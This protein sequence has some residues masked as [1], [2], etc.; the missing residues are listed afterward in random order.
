[1]RRVLTS[2]VLAAILLLSIIVVSAPLLTAHDPLEIRMDQVLQPPSGD[3]PIGT[4]E[5][6]RDV[7]ARLLYGGRIS[8]AV[9]FLSM[10]L[11]VF[12]GVLL[13]TISGLAGGITDRVIMRLADLLL[14]IPSLLLM[15]GFLAIMPQSL[16]S[17]ILVISVTGWMMVARIVRTDIMATKQ[18]TYVLAAMKLGAGPARSFMHHLLPQCI[19]SII[20]LAVSSASHAILAEA[21]LSFLGLGIPQTIPSWG[22]MLTGAQFHLLSGAWWLAVFPGLCI[23]LTIFLIHALGDRLQASPRPISVR[24]EG[25]VH[26][27]TGTRQPDSGQ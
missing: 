3:H 17:V 7:W 5:L 6:G 15:I 20:V 4:D 19:P 22:N 27:S 1:M 26:E 12:W 10:I 21:T 16:L 18:K 2:P 14:S 23:A 11:T 9:G 8:L 25:T 13:G 24:K